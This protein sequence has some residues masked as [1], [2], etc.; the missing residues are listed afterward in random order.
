MQNVPDENLA[1]LLTYS[2][3]SGAKPPTKLID[4]SRVCTEFGFLQLVQTEAS[5]PYSLGTAFQL[6][7]PI[8]TATNPQEVYFLLIGFLGARLEPPETQP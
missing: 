7:S 3:S 2:S 1:A 8:K 6:I 5:L 4:L